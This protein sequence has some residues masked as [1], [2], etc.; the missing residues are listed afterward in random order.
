MAT[1]EYRLDTYD[2]CVFRLGVCYNARVTAKNTP[3]FRRRASLSHCLSIPEW[4]GTTCILR[5]NCLR[6]RRRT[7]GCL[8]LLGLLVGRSLNGLMLVLAR[9][10]LCCAG[11]GA[12]W[13]HVVG[14][15]IV[16]VDRR[17]RSIRIVHRRRGH[18]MHPVRL[19][20]LA[21]GVVIVRVGLRELIA[22]VYAG[23]VP[24]SNEELGEWR[25][26]CQQPG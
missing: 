23:E 6:R 20:L 21:V 22:R 19:W 17:T 11:W 5:R 13:R 26:I 3:M 14:L 2:L 4:I 1:V 7:G 8:V 15:H 18:R 24:T 16:L 10:N 25:G 9:I 12:W